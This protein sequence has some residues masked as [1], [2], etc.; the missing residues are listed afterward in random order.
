M[1]LAIAAIV[2]GGAI[3]LMIYHSSERELRHTAADIEVFAKRARTISLLQQ[4]PYALEFRPGKVRLMPLA[5]AGADERLT[6]AGNEIGGRREGGEVPSANAPV[7]DEL[8]INNMNLFIRHWG[9]DTWVEMDD[10]RPEVWRFDPDGLCEPVTIR[11]AQGENWI[12]NEFHPL[13]A[14]VRETYME[15]KQ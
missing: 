2:I 3:G 9:S 8:V 15:V 10:R 6:A 13:T 12:E 7:R 1:V 11:L 4:K 5:E 14:S